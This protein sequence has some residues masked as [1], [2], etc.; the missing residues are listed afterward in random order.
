MNDVEVLDTLDE[1]RAAYSDLIGQRMRLTLELAQDAATA[2]TASAERA[3]QLD[4]A[5]DDPNVRDDL[6]A[7]AGELHTSMSRF[8]K[9]PSSKDFHRQKGTLVRP[10]VGEPTHHYGPRP[11][12][13]AAA[14][15]RH[16]GYPWNVASGTSVRSAARGLVVYAHSFEGY[17][18]LVMIDHG[19]GYHTLYAHLSDI[20]VRQGDTVGRGKVLGKSGDTGSLDGPK[21]Y[22]ELRKDGKPIN[23]SD[24]FLQTK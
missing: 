23:P 8:L 21:L 12:V 19:S 16:T 18:Q 13:S 11:T 2:D 24:W 14:T 9:N 1:D 10:I 3:A 5:K 7:T 17:G 20:D 4:S 22:F 15:V 6:E